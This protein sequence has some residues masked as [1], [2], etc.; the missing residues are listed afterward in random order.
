M[1]VLYLKLHDGEDVVA[2]VEE[3]HGGMKLK[4][5]ARLAFT[6]QGIAMMQMCPFVTDKEITI[7]SNFIVYTGTPED[8]IKNGYNAK[9][10]S[11]LVVASGSLLHG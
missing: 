7:P 3:T 1:P 11:G 8:E 5:P 2:D 9:F 4:N 10:G 6:Q